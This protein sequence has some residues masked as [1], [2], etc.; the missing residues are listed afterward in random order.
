[1]RNLLFIFLLAATPGLAAPGSPVRERINLDR[2]WKFSFGH[3]VDG[4]ADYQY[5]MSRLFAKTA[6]NYG[7]CIV[8]DFD[9]SA[10]IDVDIPHDWAVA[11]PFEY[12]P[13]GDVK[14]HGYKP[15]GGGL[16]P[17]Y[18]IGWYRKRFS[19]GEACNG[20]RLVLTFDGVFRN[21]E[22][23]VNNV[24]C[25][26]HFSGYTER[27]YD[28]SDLLHDG[29]GRENVI[30]VRVDA[31]KFEGWFYEGAGIYRHVWLDV[32]DP[33]HFP[34]HGVFIRTELNETCTR[35]DV[36]VR[37]EVENRC[38]ESRRAVVVTRIFSPDGTFVTETPPATLDLS[39]EETGF[40]VSRVSCDNP[41]LW[42]LDSPKRYRAVSCIVVGA[43]TVD[44]VETRF[45]IRDIRVDADKGLFLN[46]RNIKLQGVCCHQDH[47]GVGSALPDYLHYYRIGLLKEMG[48]NAY[49]TS[50]NPP[51]PELL[52]ACD[53]LG[54]L[55]LDEVRA[56]NSAPEY[57]SQLEALVLRDRNHPSVFMWSIGNEEETCQTT[58]Q[59][60]RMAQA[61][62]RRIRALDP[63]RL[64]T[65]G[66]NVGNVWEGVNEV[67]PVRGFNYNL[68]GIDD[69]RKAHPE[70]PILGSEVGSTVSTRGIY[71]VDSTRCYL[72]DFDE[73]YPP[74]A[75]TAEQWWTMAADRDWFMGGF[76]W[77]GFDY[78]GEPTPF[79]WPNI[80]SHF[81]VMDMCGFPKNIY[82]YYQSWWTDRD[83]LHVAPHWNWPGKEGEVIRVWVNSNADDVELFHNGHSLGRKKMPV[84]GHLEWK[85]VYRPG[86]LKAVARKGGRRIVRTVRTTG[87][88]YRI[89]LE[90]SK[91]VLRADGGDAV[92]VNV[93]VADRNGLFVPDASLPIA[94]SVRGDAAIIGV[95]NGDPSCHDP[96]QCPEGTWRRSLFNGRCQV[97]LKAGTTLSDIELAACS[98]GVNPAVT[99]IKQQ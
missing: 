69:Y 93:S 15:V 97:I 66:A 75:S 83:V 58:P 9:D 29:P 4:A 1:M 2:A 89:V 32:F 27:S 54:M 71:Q 80:H 68:Y 16:Y 57:L 56:L 78:R 19:L 72:T 98:E 14:A 43:D 25:G 85:V 12:T 5:A 40:L 51:A 87:E 11:L 50:H 67:I 77:T 28:I 96:D 74:W 21:S 79:E 36:I 94:F 61:M 64:I 26:R 48:V 49:R 55:V 70:Q 33:L 41:V 82:Y 62:M 84:N 76:V 91:T 20:K 99:T 90:P 60:R 52:D 47:A 63:S 59:G 42:D 17:Q 3:A 65:Y 31:S 53:S 92:V 24:Y 34:R 10:W 22:V 8:P 23:W 38:D 81:G 30:V 35:A 6:E 44:R 39:S 37:T 13:N 73:N 7:T 88:P 86:T 45:G 46:G 95:G 18:S